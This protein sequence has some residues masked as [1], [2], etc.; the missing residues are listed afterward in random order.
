MAAGFLT[1]SSSISSIRVK[2][3][4]GFIR[5]RARKWVQRLRQSWSR[6]FSEKPA[7]AGFVGIAAAAGW[8]GRVCA[9]NWSVKEAL[10]FAVAGRMYDNNLYQM[11]LLRER[12]LLAA[13]G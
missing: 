4:S 13:N 9:R 11:V 5:R 8:L 7:L 10:T 6:F 12:A 2:I 3:S 1:K